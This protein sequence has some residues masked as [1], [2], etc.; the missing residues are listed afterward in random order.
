MNELRIILLVI[1][2][3][4]IALI[5]FWETLKQK[6]NLRSRIDNV[7]AAGRNTTVTPRIQPVPDADRDANRKLADFNLFV[8]QDE[9][10]EPPQANTGMN[11]LAG[12]GAGPGLWNQPKAE[13]DNRK[14]GTT[15]AQEIMVIYITAAKQ[16]HFAGPD[17][18]KAAK[19]ADMEY[20][21][22]QIFHHHGPDRKHAGRPLFSLAN[23]SEPGYFIMND[24][25][26]F[27]TR[28]LA[29]FMCL[30]AEIGGDIAFEFMLESAQKLAGALGGELRGADHNRLDEDT[31]NKLRAIANLY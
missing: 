22:M 14:S 1:G 5:Y 30:P 6:R 13:V 18:L 19:A 4:V 28:G 25:Q 26:T 27:T 15:T 8:Y 11:P 23:I 24:M 2:I 7:H 17:I 31:I 10:P 29:L 16:P 12:T 21:D 20:G 3:A 9:T